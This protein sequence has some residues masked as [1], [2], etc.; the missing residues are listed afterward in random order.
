MVFV[1]SNGVYET[2]VVRLGLAN[3]DFTEIVSGA[4]EGEQ[5]A[6]LGA[7][8]I[9]VARDSSN[10]RF[11]QMTGGGMPGMQKS[12][13][14]TKSGEKSGSPAPAGGGARPRQ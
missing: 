5:V 11:K 13:S 3:F 1:K 6:L 4:N 7:A 2:R 10:A 9:Q 8:A 14:D 12:S